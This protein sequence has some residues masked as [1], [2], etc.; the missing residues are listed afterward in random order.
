VPFIHRTL[1]FTIAA[2]H[3]ANTSLQ[4]ADHQPHDPL[5][6]RYCLTDEAIF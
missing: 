6:G 2:P 3:K 5:K 1:Q 4:I